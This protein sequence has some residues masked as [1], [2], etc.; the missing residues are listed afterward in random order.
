M[1]TMLQKK[2]DVFVF[3]FCS[4]GGWPYHLEYVHYTFLYPILLEDQIILIPIVMYVN[5]CF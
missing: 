5:V 1:K 3:I 4:F 2:G